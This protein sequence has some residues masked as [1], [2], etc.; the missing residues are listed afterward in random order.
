MSFEWARARKLQNQWRERQRAQAIQGP[1][2][3]EVEMV[4]PIGVIF[5]GQSAP[6]ELRPLPS[7]DARHMD[8][9]PRENAFDPN[10]VRSEGSEST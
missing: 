8:R 6:V 9:S 1:D 10:Y 4:Y 2:A 3:P 7:E 5:W